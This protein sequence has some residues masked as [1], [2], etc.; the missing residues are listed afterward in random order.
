MYYHYF[1]SANTNLL[2]LLIISIFN[3]RLSFESEHNLVLPLTGISP[4]RSCM[5]LNDYWRD[6]KPVVMPAL[7][8]RNSASYAWHLGKA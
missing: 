6:R 8:F 2:A 4:N 1:L 3:H 5:R 7:K